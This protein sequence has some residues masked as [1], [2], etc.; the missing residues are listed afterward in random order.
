MQDGLDGL[1]LCVKAC[2]DSVLTGKAVDA[3]FVRTVA[4]DLLVWATGAVQNIPEIE[5][6][7]K[8]HT[9]TSLEYFKG[10]KTVEGPRVL[11]IGAGRTGLE[12]AEKLGK[13]G[14]DVV[15]T[16]RT[17]PIGSMMEMITKKLTLMRIDQM[18]KVTLMPHTTVKAFK[19][20]SVEVEKD[21]E[22]LSLEPLQTVIFAS[23]ML[24]APEPD[25]DIK[26]LMENIE[27]IGDARE[28]QDIF[29]AVRAGYELA[30]K[31]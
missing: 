27:V 2:S 19:A 22:M 23:G 20:D 10:E 31:Y 1:E 16:K 6:L 29:T 11:V 25:E 13:E 4:P 28:I 9:M 26:K 8:Q 24:S 21:G 12:I 7:S 15:A 14:Y 30:C 3:D 18:P 17:D 5:G